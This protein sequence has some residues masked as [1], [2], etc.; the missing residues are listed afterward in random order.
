MP[1]MT[2]RPLVSGSLVTASD[3]AI[4][5]WINSCPIPPT[6]E[7]RNCLQCIFTRDKSD[8]PDQSPTQLSQMWN[9][10]DGPKQFENMTDDR[11]KD[12]ITASPSTIDSDFNQ[13]IGDDMCDQFHTDYWRREIQYLF[14][15][16]RDLVAISCRVSETVLNSLPTNAPQMQ[17]STMA[18]RESLACRDTQLSRK[19]PDLLAEA[20]PAPWDVMDECALPDELGTTS[21][22]CLLQML[23]SDISPD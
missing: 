23:D 1:P 10:Q 18:T 21:F 22:D 8:E 15:T 19:E 17:R 12:V 7:L 9:L 6:V 4:A 11:P 5:A 2:A 16:C 3:E 14:R 20:S 13:S